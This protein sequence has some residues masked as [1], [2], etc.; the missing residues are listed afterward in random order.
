ME[1]KGKI[2]LTSL[3]TFWKNLINWEQGKY[4]SLR[5]PG[6][7][8]LLYA[9]LAWL[10]V[11]NM[12]FAP[13]R[14]E[15][16]IPALLAAPEA[17]LGAFVGVV[18]IGA[19]GMEV[20]GYTEQSDKA[21]AYAKATWAWGNEEMK[22]AVVNSYNAAVAAGDKVF[23]LSQDV[24]KYWAG[25]FANMLALNK[26]EAVTLPGGLTFKNT[27]IY[28]GTLTAPSSSY[29]ILPGGFYTGL[30]ADTSSSPGIHYAFGASSLS[31]AYPYTFNTVYPFEFSISN[32]LPGDPVKGRDFLLTQFGISG[33]TIPAGS[34]DS[35]YAN[36]LPKVRDAFPLALPVPGGQDFVYTPVAN[37]GIDVHM[38][39]D[40]TLAD[41]AGKVYT[42]DQ[43]QVK[44]TPV[45]RVVT[46][47]AGNPVKDATG[48]PVI[49]VPV[50]AV[51]VGDAAIP[52]TIVNVK[53]GDKVTTGDTTANPPLDW[54][55]QPTESIN[56]GPLKLAG[57]AL[58]KKFPFSIP[59]DI[60][61]QFAIFD[62]S[63]KTPVIAIDQRIPVFSTE[64]RLRFTIDFSLF[65]PVVPLVNW[66][67]IIAGDL[68]MILSLRKFLPE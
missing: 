58:T 37:P 55:S 25:A 4:L 34:V 20:F 16:A 15:A 49:G 10:I 19:I 46:D 65:N 14:S 5:S 63:P 56:W 53:T 62:V 8:R 21:M 32:N 45:P 29:F 13:Q 66:F 50:G 47:A 2:G 27:G 24:A 42:P 9:L 1:W 31:P 61:A 7:N 35:F 30:R 26:P 67:L 36:D 18:A 44:A 38:K 64:M 41:D 39:N 28:T 52:G 17:A 48:N 23:T 51:G 3:G 57:G 11:C 59:W 54:S 6:R 33:T 22:K 68:G 60:A 40:G 12:V 43:V